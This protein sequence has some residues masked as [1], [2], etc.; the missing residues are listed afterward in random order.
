MDDF[1]K[2]IQEEVEKNFA[3][4][5][6][7]LPHLM[8]THFGEVAL[9]RH[10]SIIEFFD[11]FEDAEKCARLAFPDRLYSFQ[12]V[13]DEPVRLGYIGTLLYA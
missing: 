11:T 1:A 7:E 2:R 3:F 5:Q 13:D 8:L 6:K 9:L 4:F 10:E 12:E